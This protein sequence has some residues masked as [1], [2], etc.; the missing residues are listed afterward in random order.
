[1]KASREQ[2]PSPEIA[3]GSATRSEAHPP[4][5]RQTVALQSE[6]AHRQLRRML[7][8]PIPRLIASLSLPTMVSM[9]VTAIYSAADAWFV[10]QLST[11]ESAAV[12]VFF[13]FMA[14]IQAFGFMLGQGA[15]SR[16]S[17][18]LGNAKVAQARERAATSFYASCVIGLLLAVVGSFFLRPLLLLL[19]ADLSNLREA[20]SYA[21][22]LLL[23]APVFCSSFVMNNLLRAEGKTLYAM[24]GLGLGGLL[25]M[26]LDPLLIFQFHL[27]IQGAAIATAISQLVAWAILFGMIRSKH[28]ALSLAPSYIAKD[29]KIYI[30]TFRLGCPSLMRQGLASLAVSFLNNRALAIGGTEAVSAFSIVGRLNYFVMALMLG[31]GQGYQ[32]VIG[33][34]YGAACYQRVRKAWRFTASVGFVLM[35][36]PA[37]LFILFSPAIINSFR[38]DPAVVAIGAPLLRY[39]MAVLPFMALNVSTNMLLQFSGKAE[40]ATLLAACRQGLY[41]FP[42]V[43]FLPLLLGLPGLMLSQSVADALTVLTTIPFVW[44]YFRRLPQQEG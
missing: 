23:A 13:P 1:M 2:L 3:K 31:L 21:Q 34:N 22:I 32:P 42:A 27:G 41:F 11:G 35:A 38:P 37:L 5:E 4:A 43:F 36:I 39:Q 26:V 14:I 9:L 10:G 40:A 28:S 12:G 24:V 33:Y 8:T 18:F 30:E 19:G 16:I 25:N 15:G 44:L 6:A 20:K 17:R 29:P 7:D